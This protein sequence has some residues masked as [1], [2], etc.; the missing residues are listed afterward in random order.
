MNEQGITISA[1]GKARGGR[2]GRW[3]RFLIRR[4]AMLF[5]GIIVAVFIGAGLL[6]PWIAPYPYATQDLVSALQSPLS[7]HHL[8]GTDQFGRDLLSRILFGAR[9]SFIFAFGVTLFSIVLGVVV[10]GISGYFGGAVDLILAAV[11]DLMWAF[12]IVLAAVL[13]VG[14]LGPGLLPAALAITVVNWAGTARIVRGEVIA[15]RER[16][17][18]EAARA[19]GRGHLFIIFRHMIPNAL[20]AV[21]VLASF[22]MGIAILVEA[23]LSFIGLGAQPPLPSWGDLL[24]EGWEYNQYAPWLVIMPGVSIVVIVLGFNVLGDA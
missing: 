4:P 21:L 10:G 7:P 19:L 3:A 18:V 8:L 2:L 16:E 6:A 15:L 14:L 13:F 20:P 11:I 24:S 9:T 23:A 12:P 5:G 1:R 22:S 17:F